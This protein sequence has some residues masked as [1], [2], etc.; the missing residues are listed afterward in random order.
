MSEIL[1]KYLED[2]GKQ[3]TSRLL[4]KHISTLFTGI[5]K[6]KRRLNVKTGN[7]DTFYNLAWIEEN[8]TKFNAL[9]FALPDICSVVRRSEDILQF[10]IP[11]AVSVNKIHLHKE[12]TLSKE[13]WH[14]SVF[15]RQVCPSTL[16]LDCN[17]DW[18]LTRLM[19]CS[20]CRYIYM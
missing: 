5:N 12:V 14:I 19:Y 20:N 8:L 17:L 11:S 2:T 1:S 3:I 16:G 7:T 18:T 13:K 10:R 4:N 15:Q 6:C 9:T